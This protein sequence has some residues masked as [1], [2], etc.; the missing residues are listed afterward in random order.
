MMLPKSERGD[1]TP[2]ER[3]NTPCYIGRTTKPTKWHPVSGTVVCATVD[4]G[5]R[6]K[7]N[8][9]AI[10]KWLRA[11]LIIE[12]VPVWW[13]RLHMLTAEPYRPEEPPP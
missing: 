12:R 1:L 7:E 8:A 13:V 11:G 4:D 6:V 2:E 9:R 10:G 5:T 3:A